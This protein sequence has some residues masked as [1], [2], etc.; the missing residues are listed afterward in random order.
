M[1]RKFGSFRLAGMEI[2][3]EEHPFEWIEGRMGVLREFT[4]GPFEWFKSAV[5]LTPRGDGGTTL[6][7]T[8]QIQTRNALGRIVANIEAG[9]KG[10]RALDRIYR[11]IDQSLQHE[12]NNVLHDHLSPLRSWID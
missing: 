12:R 5:E 1:L 6:V 7:H 11:R 2:E 4:R 3:W 9:W 8:V 10:G